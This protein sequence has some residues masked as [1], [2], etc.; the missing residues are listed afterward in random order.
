[1]DLMLFF[2]PRP[3]TADEPLDEG[4]RHA[5]KFLPHGPRLYD[6]VG[7]DLRSTGYDG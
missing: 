6:G 3:L 7:M 2:V 4:L 1:M 5:K